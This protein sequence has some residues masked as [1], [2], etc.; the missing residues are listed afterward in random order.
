MM[1]LIVTV[2][3][4]AWMF[5]APVP[6]A[7]IL[8]V[9]EYWL[10]MYTGVECTVD[11]YQVVTNASLEIVM[12]RIDFLPDG[13]VLIAADDS[14]IPILA[15][16]ETGSILDDTNPVQEELIDEYS[17]QL[18][19]IK[20]NNLSNTETLPLWTSIISKATTTELSHS[21]GL[22]TNWH[23]NLP[24][25]SLC[26][27]DLHTPGRSLVGCVATATSQI[28][29]YFK[30]WD[31]SFSSADSYTSYQNG[32]LTHV[33]ADAI[34]HNFPNFTTLNSNMNSVVSKF[35]SGQTLTSTD[36]A[37]LC[38]AT[39]ILEHM[40][41]SNGASGSSINNARAAFAKLK[42]NATLATRSG[43]SDPAWK[44]MIVDELDANRPI[45]YRGVSAP[46]SGHAFILCGYRAAGSA[47]HFLVNW[48]WGANHNGGYYSLDALNAGGY[49]FVMNQMMLYGIKPK[50]TL[51]Q[52]VALSDGATNLTGIILKAQKASGPTNYYN[53]DAGGLIDIDL[54]TA[55]DYWF[56]L[57]HENNA[58]IPYTIGLNMHKGLNVLQTTPIVLQ[59]RPSI[60]FVPTDITTIQ[61]G[62]DQVTDGGTVIILNGTHFV[63]GLSWQDKHIKLQGQSLNGVILTNDG[64]LP[65]INL[66][67][68][69]INNTDTIRNIIFQDCSLRGA[70]SRGAAIALH[71]G[72]SPHINGCDFDNNSVGEAYTFEYQTFEGVGG[73]VFIGGAENQTSKPKFYNCKF[74]N[75]YTML[76][77]GG[78]AVAL[79][80]IAE[81]SICKFEN[82]STKDGPVGLDPPELDPPVFNPPVFNPP[83]CIEAAGAILIYTQEM[84]G[85]ITFKNCTFTNNTGKAEA[86]DIFVCN[87]DNLDVLRV[88][89]CTFRKD[90]PVDDRKHQLSIR[91]LKDQDVVGSVVHYSQDMHAHFLFKNNRFIGNDIGAVYF[92][93]YQGKNSLTFIN[94]VVAENVF[95]GYGIYLQYHGMAP[96]NPDYFRCDNNTFKNIL[97]SGV[98]LFSGNVYTI[99]NNVFDNCSQYGVNWGSYPI[100]N[101]QWATVALTVNNC[102][103]TDSSPKYDYTGNANCVLT[104]NSVIV[105]EDTYLD[106]NYVPIWTAS[107]M[108]PCIDA[109][110]GAPDP[111]GTPRDIGAK[112][113]QEH[114]YREYSYTNPS[115]RDRWHWV[116]YPVLNTVTNDAL[117]ASEFF[118]E[119]LDTYLD[120]GMQWQPTCLDTIVWMERGEEEYISWYIE[121]W[122]DSQYTHYISSPQGYKVKL[123]QDFWGTV[124]IRES[125]FKTPESLPFPIYAGVENWLG[126]FKEESAKPDEVF[127]DIWDDI[128]MVRGK[129]WS[130]VRDS[131][132]QLTGKMGTL[133]YGDM[134][135]IITNNSHTFQWGSNNPTPPDVKSM[136]QHFDFDEKQ[137]YIPVYV[138]LPDSVMP[139]LKEIGL[140]LDGICKGAVVV[141]SDY[142]QISAYVDSEGEL[143]DSD[144]ELVF[145]YDD[146]KRPDQQLRTTSYNPGRLQTKYGVSG[147]RYPYFEIA[148][149]KEDLGNI[150]PAELSLQQNYPNPFNPTTTISYFLPE[151]GNI[152]LDIYNLKGQLL[153]T[154]VNADQEA[155][156]HSVTWNGTDTKGQ[157]VASGVYFYR[158]SSPHKTLTKRMLLMK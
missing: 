140:Y 155:G 26:P 119:I 47:T 136:P 158:L 82:N 113:A 107:T 79:Y 116:S 145:H 55:G 30:F 123:K 56:T 65:A 73:A 125:G 83:P 53:A 111:D 4:A 37:S 108:S 124:T 63:S 45:Q 101:P 126:Y 39:G 42:Y 20:A 71:N 13:F 122:T 105:V 132:G 85:E 146:S 106:A 131:N 52:S 34:I 48:G 74:T 23:Q 54:P 89:D 109:G 148:I 75:N 31:Y 32:F 8:Q 141:D 35:N 60:V 153:T 92:Q 110:Y 66:E 135:I 128:T 7:T 112:T 64:G 87:V 33:D 133:H 36:M 86:D 142:E 88:E 94:N 102:I 72:A 17:A 114:A 137:D 138:S 139:D 49:N 77:N 78:G 50:V 104:E 118:K 121:N 96:Q 156:K 21:I 67:W 147:S 12:Y 120:G 1:L 150:I 10:E 2:L 152:Q 22:N 127:A 151:A 157:S 81:F 144:L 95:V 38:F 28:L 91:L 3:I 44:N 24:Y 57:Y 25:N 98:V 6:E 19:D 154:I 46:S 103:F 18:T 117:Q 134:V 90:A 15:Y 100:G 61:E 11:A 80:G 27:I 129:S 43:F 130:L 41:Y 84:P 59:R 62:I 16:S 58:Y 51:N 5:A 143:A 97:G 68:S 99:N 76:G 115:S 93:D 9:A 29:N 40:Q 14:S 69:G 149:D 70:G